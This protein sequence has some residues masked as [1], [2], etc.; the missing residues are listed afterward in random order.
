MGE[1]LGSGQGIWLHALRQLSGVMVLRCV[2]MLQCRG[3][4]LLGSGVGM[5]PLS[6]EGQDP[7]FGFMCCNTSAEMVMSQ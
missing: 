2:S 1:G 7:G 4:L 3:T 6:L 5:S